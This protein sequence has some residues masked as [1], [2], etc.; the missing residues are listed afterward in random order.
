MKTK[1]K[2]GDSVDVYNNDFFEPATESGC[3]VVQIP[4]PGVIAVR[5]SSDP[6]LYCLCE[7]IDG[8]WEI[9]E[10]IEPC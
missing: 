10:D 9:T 3:T 2:V 1:L 4:A 5:L 7:M 6:N 8:K